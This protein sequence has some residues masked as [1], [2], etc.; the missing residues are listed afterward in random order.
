MAYQVSYVIQGATDFIAFVLLQITRAFLRS[1][2][3]SVSSALITAHF[4]GD[5]DDNANLTVEMPLS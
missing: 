1:A 2:S 5:T 4:A 3:L